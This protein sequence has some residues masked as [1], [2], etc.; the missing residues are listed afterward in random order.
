MSSALLD[1]F[2]PRTT[3]GVLAAVLLHPEREWYL[4]DLAKHLSVPPSS[5]QRLLPRLVKAGLLTRRA[6]GNRV[7]HRADTGCPIHGELVAI[8][9]KTLGIREPLQ[10]ALETLAAKIRVAFVHGSIV[11]ARERTESDI[12]LLIVGDVAGIELA[13]ALRPVSERL[14]REVNPTRY[15]ADEFRRRVD[16]QNHFLSATLRKPRIFVIGN[17]HDLDEITR[18]KARRHR[19]D[20]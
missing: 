11:E 12:D 7:Y 3:Q 6:D 9:T 10:R 8:L 20:E 15:S 17:E 13:S 14:G 5:L 2:L 18:R 1:S 16:D 4:S 19:G